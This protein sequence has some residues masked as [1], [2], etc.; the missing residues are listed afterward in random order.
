M[1]KS[2]EEKLAEQMA[3]Y[4]SDHFFN[5]AIFANLIT[6]DYPV[7]TQEKLMELIKWVIKYG[8]RRF[9][10]EWEAGETSEGLMLADALNDTLNQLGK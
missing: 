7:Y 8:Q 2:K 4:L 6:T 10:Y 3:E 9:E 5:P 1:A